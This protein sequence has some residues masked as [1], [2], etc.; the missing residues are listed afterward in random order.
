MGPLVP[1]SDAL[2]TMQL[3][4]AAEESIRTGETVRIEAD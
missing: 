1:A 4:F 3:S 2:A